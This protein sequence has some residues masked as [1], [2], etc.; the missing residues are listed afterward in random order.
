ME[1]KIIGDKVRYKFPSDNGWKDGAWNTCLECETRFASYSR[2]KKPFCS[3]QCRHDYYNLELTCD[4]CGLPFSK[5][6]SR[7]GEFNYCSNACVGEAKRIDKAG[8]QA[9]KQTVLRTSYRK[10]VGYCEDCGESRD[11]MLCVHHIDGNKENEIESNWE[12][13]CSNC[14]RKRHLK[15]VD[16][17]L[18]YDSRVLTD[19]TLLSEF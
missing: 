18:V 3:E 2:Q 13:L 14:H 19:R 7:I 5:K 8:S 10:S 15:I 17:S 16:E 1:I 4:N 12:V 9:K 11:Y 6:K